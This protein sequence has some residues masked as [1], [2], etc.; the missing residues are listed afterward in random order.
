MS[1]GACVTV[2]PYT[3]ARAWWP[4]H[5][6]S[7]GVRDAAHVRITCSL[8]PA[9]FGVPGPGETRTPSNTVPSASR[10]RPSA[11]GSGTAS[12]RTTTV[13]APSWSR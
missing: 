5:T 7:I 6:P 10:K 3:S 9:S 1:S 4:R 8:C 2:A 13:C 12:L 11:S